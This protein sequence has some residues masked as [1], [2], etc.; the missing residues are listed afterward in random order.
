MWHDNQGRNGEREAK[1]VS[2]IVPGRMEWKNWRMP[3]ITW[4]IVYFCRD[5]IH[6]G[7]LE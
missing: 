6:H 2:Y 3:C 5:P 1:N 4:S 7:I